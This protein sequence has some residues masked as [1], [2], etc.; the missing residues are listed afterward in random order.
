M[1]E[2]VG[3]ITLVLVTLLAIVFLMVLRARAPRRSLGRRPTRA[4][5]APRCFGFSS[6]SGSA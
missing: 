5:I 2:A 6:G 3:I 4:A 1:Q